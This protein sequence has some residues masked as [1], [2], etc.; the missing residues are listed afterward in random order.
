MDVIEPSRYTPFQLSVVPDRTEVAVVPVGELDLATV[1]D[2][3]DTV[4]DLR[5]SG[6]DSILIDLRGVDFIDSTG[7]RLLLNLRNDA[8]GDGHRL[9]L[10]AP[11]QS[12]AR[13]FDITRTRGLFDWRQRFP[14]SIAVDGHGP[15]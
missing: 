3:R 5:R 1:D 7:L 2:L 15:G 6:W 8:D 12:A 10:M 13:I 11:E 14:R 9:S 4:D